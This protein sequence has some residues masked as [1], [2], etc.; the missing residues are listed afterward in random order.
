[1]QNSADQVIPNIPLVVDLDGTLI[2]TDLLHESTIR[3][4]RDQPLRAFRIPIW[5]SSGKGYLKD[6]LAKEVAFD[7]ALL[8]FN[9]PFVNWLKQEKD[10]GRSLVLCT[11]SD[12]SYAAAIAKHLPIFDKVMAS[13]E[14]LNLAGEVKAQT[15][16]MSFGIGQ[17][18]YAGNSSTDHAVWKQARNA[19]VVNA[20]TSVLHQAKASYTV[21]KVFDQVRPS[22]RV[23]GKFFRVHQWL[24]N[25]LI[26]VPFLAAH[27]EITL[28]SLSTL[29]FAIVAF[30]LCASSVYIANDLFDLE[31]DRTHPRK[32]LRPLAS[33]SIPIALG[34]AIAPLLLLIS[35]AV[36]LFVGPGFFVWLCV[37]FLITCIY[38]WYLKRIVLID[39]MTLAMLYTLRI[40]S[41]ASA[42]N[43][44][45]SFW[46]I[47]FS[48]FLFLSLSF[49][50]RYAELISQVNNAAGK[51]HGRGYFAADA[52]LI[53]NFGIASGYAA[54]V[55]LAFYLNSDVVI[56]LYKNPEI[57]WGAVPVLLFWIS[58]MW[59][60]AHRGNM[61][62]D[63][64]VFA[65]K[66]G[67]SL[68]AGACFAIVVFLGNVSLK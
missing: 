54:A 18:D 67:A 39:C 2:L 4:F 37:Y 17:F 33:G 50:K 60:Q 44:G 11:A 26:A 12:Y 6:K 62:D 31:S 8:P 49:V 42:V 21:E 25:L 68:A 32:K 53:Q 14:H 48:V 3:F 65:V 28:S 56:K 22:G 20:P 16:V 35:A 27:Q 5:L 23:W 43:L 7:P 13:N 9:K 45:L 15:L 61:N 36:A 46:L 30:S 41:G 59:V 52:S 47:A 66:D 63:P 24:K 29:F 34:V 40:I 1:M 64:L 10:L 57:I 55:V 58:W 38:S 51:A 19:V